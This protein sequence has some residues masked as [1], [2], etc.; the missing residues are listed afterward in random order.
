MLYMM[1]ESRPTATPSRK[2]GLKG[3]QGRLAY[4]SKLL[5]VYDDLGF[6]EYP[7]DR[8][9]TSAATMHVLRCLDSLIA[10]QLVHRDT[11]TPEHTQVLS[12]RGLGFVQACRPPKPK[13]NA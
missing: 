6:L 4:G 3:G 8:C 9:P 5:K 1:G 11:S 13:E 2:P 7:P 10:E 12:Y